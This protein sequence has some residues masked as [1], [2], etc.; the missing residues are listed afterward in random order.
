MGDFKIPPSG[1]PASSVPEAGAQVIPLR[2]G[3]TVG[4][5]GK[6]RGKHFGDYI[7]RQGFEGTPDQALKRR[8]KETPPPVIQ[9]V[10]ARRSSPDPRADELRQKVEKAKDDLV[11]ATMDDLLKRMFAS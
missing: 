3:T 2:D 8:T 10:L 9:G 5:E 11:V 4:P 7:V 1:K 6:P